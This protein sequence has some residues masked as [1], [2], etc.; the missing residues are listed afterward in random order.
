MDY[1]ILLEADF[2]VNA[3][4]CH[5]TRAAIE[6][7]C[8]RVFCTAAGLQLLDSIYLNGVADICVLPTGLSFIGNR[9][10]GISKNGDAPVWGETYRQQNAEQ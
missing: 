2:L 7:F 8:Q 9:H 3:D 6:N 10:K 5:Y 4:E 1:Q